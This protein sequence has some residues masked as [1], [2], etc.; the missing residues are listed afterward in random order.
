MIG[1]FLFHVANN[2]GNRTMNWNKTK[3]N[4]I[5]AGKRNPAANGNR[6][7]KKPISTK[8]RKMMTIWCDLCSRFLL[9][10]G[11]IALIHSRC[12]VCWLK[13]A[14]M[15]EMFGTN[16]IKCIELSIAVLNA[17]PFSMTNCLKNLIYAKRWTLIELSLLS[18]KFGP[19]ATK[20]GQKFS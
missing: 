4:Q 1:K 17:V 2:R 13:I 6:R 9:Y 20:N 18:K 11:R 7:W 14:L 5:L 15:H 8:L 12:V 16:R 19:E 10:S 3:N